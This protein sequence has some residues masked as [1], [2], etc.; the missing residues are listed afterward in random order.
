MESVQTYANTNVQNATGSSNAFIVAGLFQ[1]YGKSIVAILPD[2]ESANYFK[3]DIENLI[4]D[5]KVLFY[6]IR[7]P[8]HFI[9]ISLIHS[10]FSR[11]PK[12]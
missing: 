5:N 12:F 11:E 4:G 10:T 3:S 6:P 2:K 8:N 7:L 1:N 9:F